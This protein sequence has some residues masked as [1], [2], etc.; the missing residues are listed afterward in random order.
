MPLWSG[1]PARPAP[2]PAPT[3]FAL[4]ELFARATAAE[5]DFLTRSIVGELR[6]G[7]VE[8]LMID[9]VAKATG[10]ALDDVRRAVMVTGGTGG[11]ATVAGAALTGSDAALA[12]FAIAVVPTRSWPML[13]DRI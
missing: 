3:G 6:Q 1:S 8:G 12:R 7:A 10:V 4:A 9:A 11:L 5:Q 2:A 13:V